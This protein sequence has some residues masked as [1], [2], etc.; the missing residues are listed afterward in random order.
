LVFPDRCRVGVFGVFVCRCSGG[1]FRTFRLFG[2]VLV[3]FACVL[4]EG[5]GFGV[6]SLLVVCMWLYCCLL[7]GAVLVWF[8]LFCFCWG[9]LPRPICV[10]LLVVL[11]LRLFLCHVVDEYFWRW[12]SFSSFCV[13]S[14]T[15]SWSGV[16]LL[17]SSSAVEFWFVSE[18]SLVGVV[19]CLSAVV[20]RWQVLPSCVWRFWLPA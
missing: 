11:W 19:S 7:S 3:V 4:V 17:R 5:G 15:T 2:G 18:F 20:S 6:W 9:G 16:F 14:W 12:I 8:L 1:V 13:A 10:V